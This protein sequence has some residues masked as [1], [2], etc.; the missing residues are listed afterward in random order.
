MQ[1][2]IFKSS[3]S[4]LNLIPHVWTKILTQCFLYPTA[5]VLFSSV[6]LTA[7]DSLILSTTSVVALLLLYVVLLEASDHGTSIF[8]Y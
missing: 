6:A 1:H 5:K 4:S 2:I 3:T 7:D 8:L